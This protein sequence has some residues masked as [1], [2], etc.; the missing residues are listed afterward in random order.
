MFVGHKGMSHTTHVFWVKN[1]PALIEAWETALK[2]ID[3]DGD[4]TISTGVNERTSADELN[5]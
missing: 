2:V 5:D 1:D 4:N 3:P